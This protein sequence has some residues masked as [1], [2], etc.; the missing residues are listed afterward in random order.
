MDSRKGGGGGG[1][2]RAVF[3]VG[4][5]FLS[6]K[7]THVTLQTDDERNVIPSFRLVQVSPRQNTGSY[8]FVRYFESGGG[9]GGG[10][11]EGGRGEREGGREREIEARSAKH[12]QFS[13]VL[14]ISI[15]LYISRNPPND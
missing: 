15:Y 13:H 9:E 8:P 2:D 10:R 12:L 7:K 6:I 11:G 1:G 4:L 3:R 5:L 14:S